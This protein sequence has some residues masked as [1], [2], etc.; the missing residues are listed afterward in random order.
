[1]AEKTQEH[2]L[3]AAARRLG[4]KMVLDRYR[5]RATGQDR[6]FLRPIWDARRAV[7][8]LPGGGCELVTISSGRRKAAS[9]MPL[10]E[11]EQLLIHWSEPRPLAPARL[12]WQAG[13][14]ASSSDRRT[15]GHDQTATWRLG[16]R[17]RAACRRPL[18]FFSN[19]TVI[20]RSVR[21]K[22]DGSAVATAHGERAALGLLVATR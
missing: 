12:P 11:V 4:L 18:C 10:D 7:R 5:A 20:M 9:L 13:V 2:R 19:Q 21:V 17:S 22:E 6:Y 3:Q 14:V 16:G 8:A 15:E 1:M